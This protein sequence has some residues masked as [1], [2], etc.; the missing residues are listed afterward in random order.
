MNLRRLTS[1]GLL[2]GQLQGIAPTQV[3]TREFTVAEELRFSCAAPSLDDHARTG[4]GSPVPSSKAGRP[5]NPEVRIERVIRSGRTM[6][7][8]PWL[9]P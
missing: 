5:N 7:G 8:C 6:I 1:R 4:F 3:S 9:C 2:A